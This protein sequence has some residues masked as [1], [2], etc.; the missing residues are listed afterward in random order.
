[1]IKELTL[2]TQ[3]EG[4]K[5]DVFHS[6]AFKNKAE[7]QACYQQ[8]KAR[9][10][11]INNWGEIS[12]MGSADFQLTNDLGTS[13]KGN[14]TIGNYI[15][16][17]IPAPKLQE[18]KGCD[19]VIIEKVDEAANPNNDSEEIIVTVRPTQQPFDDANATTHFFDSDTTSSFLIKRM[20]KTVTASEHGRN[21]IVNLKTNNVID[22][23]RNF[24]VA[25]GALLGLSDVQWKKL[26]IGL[27]K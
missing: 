21:E 3:Y 16:I 24:F 14:A 12:G 15:K 17:N 27:L 4:V 23:V 22:K 13:I 10:L 2:P 1:M 5:K 18:S 11:D 26:L 19:W 7:A 9:L 6:R 25:I 8:A 20:G